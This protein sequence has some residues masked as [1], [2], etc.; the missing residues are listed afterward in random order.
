MLCF[1]G[2]NTLRGVGVGV[3]ICTVLVARGYN[4]ACVKKRSSCA[5]VPRLLSMIVAL[6]YE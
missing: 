6:R 2:F 3:E 5:T 1:D 4:F